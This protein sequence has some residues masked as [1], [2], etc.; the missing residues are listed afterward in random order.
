MSF[1]HFL[2]DLDVTLSLRSRAWFLIESKDRSAL[3]ALLGLL[4]VSMLFELYSLRKQSL[5][6]FDLLT[7]PS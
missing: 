1:Y 3:K 2:D 6:A 7:E 4:C 5:S